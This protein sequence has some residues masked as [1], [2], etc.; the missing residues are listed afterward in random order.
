[1]KQVAVI[2]YDERAGAFHASQLEFL[3]DNRI[4]AFSMD[5][6]T[7]RK[8]G[9]EKADLYCITTD[10]LE[11]LPD[12][13]TQVE[14]DIPIVMLC[15]TFSHDILQ[16]LS[17]IPAGTD[18][19]LVNLNEP[20]AQ[21]AITKLIQLGAS[22]INYIPYYPGA[23]LGLAGGIRYAITPDERRFVP[24][25]IPHVIDVGQRQMDSATLVEIALK[26]KMYDMW[27][28][29]RWKAHLAAIA[30]NSYNFD[31]LFGRALRLESSFQSLI[32]IM[33]IGILGI[34]EQGA[35]F[36]CNKKAETIVG[37]GLADAIG[38]QAGRLFPYLPFE[39]CRKTHKKIDARL[40]KINQ[41]PV[42]VGI[43]P[44]NHNQKNM[45]FLAMLQ[46]FGEEE[47]KQHKIRSQLLNRG[48]AAKYTF[49]NI[50]G[51]S[52]AIERVREIAGKMA[53]TKASILITGE[54]GTGKELFAQAIHNASGRR[55]G[56]FIALNCGA[57]PENLL[58]SELF[59]YVD[60]AFTGARKGGKLGLFEFAH[61]GTLFLDEV[62][63]MSPMLQVKLLRV[64]Q[65]HEVMRLGD[66]RLIS[67]DVR[68]IAATNRNLEQLVL[69]GEFREDLYYRL[70]TLP[71]N[72]PPLRERPEDIIPLVEMF[73]RENGSVF[74]LSPAVRQALKN[75][76]WR[77]NVRELKNC[78]HYFSFLDKA[79]LEY[80]D[81][82]P[83]FFNSM[84][85]GDGMRMDGAYG[86][87]PMDGAQDRNPLDGAYD[88][89]PMDGAYGRN[90]MDSAHDS[91]LMQF[92]TMAAMKED[93]Y[94]YVLD[95]ILE[96]NRGRGSVGRE[97]LAR[98]SRDRGLNLSVYE[99]REIM[100]DLHTNGYI[101]VPK[102][103]GGSRITD[104]GQYILHSINKNG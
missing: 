96:S 61:Q 43:Y 102:G 74:E 68:I 104:K 49:D 82:P 65:E 85:T 26:L 31:E 70:N 36:I 93:A 58:E 69:K 20:M 2:S 1:M 78:A 10:A 81:L 55:N 15:V 88:S 30:S 7:I 28:N 25:G 29:R 54:S 77:G 11:K 72:L 3:F 41:N 22:H 103:R 40:I 5:V 51:V 14:G 8:N 60:G 9:I 17:L 98:R 21:E 75:H 42:T 4:R 79:V 39:E 44:I 76:Y 12:F 33:D 50:I 95:K 94:R 35:I 46:H 97:E 34:N 64:I 100:A 89:N 13:H 24:E 38:Q 92:K 73:S 52:P 32:D 57:L 53:G 56:P 62:E 6:P 27:D 45:G 66:T 19:L 59:G 99:V 84:V 90:P 48:H 63:G 18:V 47:E 91:T 86:R 101:T 80:E 23:D 83:G 16:Q 71:I 87:N 37:R 67:I